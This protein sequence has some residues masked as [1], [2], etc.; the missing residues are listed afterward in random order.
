MPTVDLAIKG[1]HGRVL[2]GPAEIQIEDRSRRGHT[3]RDP[4]ARGANKMPL[5]AP[6]KP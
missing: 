5:L 3:E 4:A 6:A 1:E 2:I